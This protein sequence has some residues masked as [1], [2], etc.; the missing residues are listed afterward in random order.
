MALPVDGDRTPIPVATTDADETA[1]AFSP[2]GKW[3][4]IESDVTGTAEIC[5]Q[6]FPSATAK[7]PV[8]TGGGISP[9]WGPGGDEI[10]YITPN[11]QLMA[12]SLEFNPGGGVKP[13]AARK[14]FTTRLGSGGASTR[15]YVISPDGKRFLMNTLVEQTGSPITLIL[16]RTPTSSPAL[17]SF[18][19]RAPR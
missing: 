4:A 9:T 18:Q 1:G 11:G 15:E 10:F 5:L 3:L 16:N 7:H 2:D 13:A 8:S 19:E 12:V 6:R 17:T 14:L